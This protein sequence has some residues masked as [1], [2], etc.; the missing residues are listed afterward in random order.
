VIRL[1]EKPAQ[2]KSNYAL[3]GVYMFTAAVHEAVRQLRPS[4]RGEL[5][6][7]EAIQ[8]LIDN[9]HKV[10]TTII[11]GYWKDTGNVA[12]M[13]EV[14]RRVL[15]TLESRR[16][17]EIDESSEIIGRVAIE[18]GAR[19]T[20]S[21]IVGPAVIGAR[22]VVT[23]SY[24]G[25]FSSVAEDCTILDSE[26]QYSIVLQGSLIQGVGRIEGSL[27]G[28]QVKV[29]PAAGVPKAHRLV[30]ADHSEVQIIS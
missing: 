20:G 30:L 5:E 6:I 12:D 13:L 21:R 15:E 22:T 3:V 14:N 1:V 17:G 9:G 26:L 7:T 16:L 19:V 25:P 10:K 18:A 8:W 28:R 11:T 23:D 29:T 2:P 24:V 27:I 4:A